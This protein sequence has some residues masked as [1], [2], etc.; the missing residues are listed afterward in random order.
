VTP[1]EPC[2]DTCEVGGPGVPLVLVS[3]VQILK[4]NN[5]AKP[6]NWKE[7]LY[8]LV[9][10]GPNVIYLSIILSIISLLSSVPSHLFP[11]LVYPGL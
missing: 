4:G 9:S 10:R 5:A 1:T 8:N 11:S 2:H 6:T 7:T 3:R